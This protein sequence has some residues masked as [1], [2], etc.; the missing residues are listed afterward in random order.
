MTLERRLRDIQKHLSLPVGSVEGQFETPAIND[1]ANRWSGTLSGLSA[2][3]GPSR[4]FV[5]TT[6]HGAADT[7]GLHRPTGLR[8]MSRTAIAAVTRDPELSYADLARAVFLDTETT[9]LGMGTGTYVFL[10][11]AGYLA[12]SGFTVKQFFL[13]SPGD[14][15]HVLD[16]L[17]EFL[18]AFPVLVTFNGKAFDW[19]LLENRYRLHRR[20]PP[21]NDPP[22]VDLLHPARRLWKRRLESCALSSLE[23]T[24]LRVE[25]TL[26]DVAG[27]EIPLR[28]FRYQRS[29]NPAH[30]SGV[31]YHNL[32]DILSL[33]T[34]TIH[35]DRVVSDPLGGLVD[36]PSDLFCIGKVHE[37]A[38]D[39]EMA[40]YCYEEALRRDL[41]GELV[42]DC[43]LRLGTL[44]K[45]ERRWD[46]AVR[47][48]ES[49]VDAGGHGSLEARVELA[50]YHEHV[51]RDY[52]AAIDHVQGALRLAEVY[53][54]SWPDANQRD[55]EHRLSRLLNR[56]VRE[57][58]WSGSYG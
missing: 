38:G 21:L 2:P 17:A 10:V 18:S 50:K 6:P 11:G 54:S 14:E 43:W 40:A 13:D 19:P 37:L 7:H 49:L 3:L 36:H 29:G 48:W 45:R 44:H 42:G 5:V 35:L 12:E 34:L 58:A 15:G 52:I 41:S 30:L 24:V 33:A 32:I 39:G 8:S 23:R 27:W 28:Y 9:G 22:H 57:R 26:D 1:D 53:N 31:F 46:L 20:L 16:A 55:L 51:E 47:A 56:S 25:R 4:S